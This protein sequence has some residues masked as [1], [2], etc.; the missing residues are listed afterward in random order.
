VRIGNVTLGLG[1][2][3]SFLVRIA[4]ASSLNIIIINLIRS[5]FF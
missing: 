3:I 1:Y 2:R 5:P 4:L